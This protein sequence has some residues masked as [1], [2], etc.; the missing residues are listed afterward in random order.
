MIYLKALPNHWK[1]QHTKT[2]SYKK[3]RLIGRPIMGVNYGDPIFRV[4]HILRIFLRI[5]AHIFGIF[6]AYFG[7]AP[8]HTPPDYH[9]WG[10]GIF[11]KVKQG[12]KSQ[13]FSSFQFFTKILESR[14]LESQ[15]K[16]CH[17][18]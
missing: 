7:L 9:L 14:V 10:G 1:K 12:S 5:F 16:F 13:Q 2:A 17:F 8:A 6:C 4:A 11:L 18:V 3:L 15:D